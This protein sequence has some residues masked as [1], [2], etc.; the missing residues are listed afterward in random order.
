MRPWRRSSTPRRPAG[1]PDFRRTL[2][3]RWDRFIEDILAR[4]ENGPRLRTQALLGVFILIW[5]AAAL[6]ERPVPDAALMES[7]LAGQPAM[8][9][10]FLRPIVTA[11]LAFVSLETLRHL[12]VPAIVLF[13]GLRTGAR[14]LDDLF[15]LKDFNAAQNYLTLALFGG[16]YPVM[17]I[18]D[19]EVTAAGQRTTLYRIG[20]PGYVKVH[21]GNAALFERVTGTSDIVAATPAQFLHGFERLREVVDLRDQLR[22]RA[23]LNVYTK[24]GLRVKAVDVQA[25]FRVWGGQQPRSQQNPYPFEPLALRRVVYGRAVG[26]GGQTTAWAESVADLTSAEVA[27]YIGSRLLKDL[28][29]QKRKVGVTPG[30]GVETGHAIGSKPVRPADLPD[31]TRR[32]LS[33][34]FYSP[35]TAEA[36]RATGVELIWIGVGTLDTPDEVEQELIDAWQSDTQAKIKS[37]TYKPEDDR[38]RAQTQV[39]EKFLADIAEW[40]GRSMPLAGAWQ[41]ARSEGAV[42]M[43]ALRRLG[44][45]DSAVDLSRLLGLFGLKLSALRDDL[46]DRWPLPEAVGGSLA[47]LQ[48]LAEDIIIIGGRADQPALAAAA[49]GP[50]LPPAAPM[51]EAAAV[52][53]GQLF[54]WSGARGL[55][56]VVEVAREGARGVYVERQNGRDFPT[57]T[58]QPHERRRFITLSD[59][60]RQLASGDLRPEPY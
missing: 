7:L 9:V 36:F 50:A 23:E 30:V 47:H 38:R 53:E 34:S 22:T 19:G 59:L 25:V 40:W 12:V 10:V 42:D 31:N 5:G 57:Q 2:R 51:L 15:E 41:V 33:L 14:Y 39:I 45:A 28:I 24:D 8:I 46:K 48:T 58:G 13:L 18:R 1:G 55:V 49:A 56:R 35:T 27:R 54:W 3:A 37:G 26:D 60:E 52:T 4:D 17:E 32:P 16:A 21:L 29:A 6:V 44:L 43:G 20:G 11:V